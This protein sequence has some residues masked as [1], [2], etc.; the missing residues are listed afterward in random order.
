MKEK[1]N[2]SLNEKKIYDMWEKNGLFTPNMD[3]DKKPF[4]IVIPPPNI[5]G[6]LHIGHALQQ[7]I[8]DII[9]R[10]ERMKGKNTLW[11]VG[12]DHAGIATQIL[13]EQQLKLLEKKDKYEYS[14]DEFIKKTW[15][16]KKKLTQS[17]NN[18]MRRLGNSV[19]WL[20]ERF[21]LDS[22]MSIAVKEAFIRLY[23]KNLIYQRK[24]I[25]HWDIKLQTVISDLEVE[26]RSVLGNLYRI[27]YPLVLDK[28][29]DSNCNHIVV[30]TTRPETLLGDTALAV[31]PEDKRYIKYVGLSV[32]VPIVNRIVPI[33][34]DKRINQKK[35]TGCVKIT[36]GHDFNDYEIALDHKLPMINIFTL[37]GKIRHVL[38]V[39]DV[40]GKES[41]IYTNVVPKNLQYIH[42]DVA[43]QSI[44]DILNTSSLL[45]KIISTTL[46][47]PYG[48]RSGEVIEP[49]LTNQWYLKMAPLAKTAIKAVQDGRIE[50][51]PKKYTKIY[52]NWMNN[53]EDWCISR[54]LWWGHQIPIWFDKHRNIFVGYNEEEVRKK[55]KLSLDT[56]LVQ[57]TDVLDTWFSSSLWTFASLGWPRKTN[58]LKLFHPTNLLVTGFDIIFFWV[59]RMIML[60]M[61]FIHDD[62]GTPQIPF[63]KILVTGLIKD[64]DGKKM[65]K[66]KGNVLDPLDMIDG[67]SLDQLVYKRTNCMMKPKLSKLI[68]ERTKIAFPNGISSTGTDVLRLTLASLSTFNKDINWDHSRLL[69]YRNFCNKVWNASRFIYMN[70]NNTLSSYVFKPHKVLSV[71]NKWILIELNNVIRSYRMSLDIYRFDVAVN[72]LYNFFWNIFCNWYLEFS[73]V[74][75][76]S[77]IIKYQQETRLTLLYVLNTF[78]RLSHPIIPYI[79]ESIWQRVIVLFSNKNNSIMIQPFPEY[80]KMDC[81]VKAILSDIGW[82]QEMTHELRNI[83]KTYSSLINHNLITIYFKSLTVEF[84]CYLKRYSEFLIQLSKVNRLIILND[85]DSFPIGLP[86]Y[87]LGTK[88]VL[89]GNNLSDRDIKDY[90]LNDINKT[91]LLLQH[92]IKFCKNKLLN[93]NFLNHA[94]EKIIQSEREKLFLLEKQVFEYTNRRIHYIK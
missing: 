39:F 61:Y 49:I 54:Q 68:T 90:L 65:S 3:K 53:I 34:A 47:L 22:G 15:I 21:T 32:M 10:Y 35:G 77:T 70:I 83:K 52:F 31:H 16:W 41:A 79:T 19:D 73:K 5:T 9:I 71:L 91:I 30:E 44:V 62:H 13:V 36:P 60:T 20:N 55:Y 43:R 72:V 26:H 14:R 6:N 63:K 78:L 46:I 89:S 1:Y 17:I 88:C 38:Q 25:S 51:I 12:T 67:I 66:S 8:M 11:Q 86:I 59:A 94:P 64:E 24:K 33:I 92:K 40:D 27:C 42:R 29:I 69:N 48:D 80:K 82:I 18:Q 84:K 37:D 57:E 4:C 75:L 50:F 23:E 81:D 2:P 28:H 58:F 74:I 93:K 76:S 85:C 56:L 7:T 87:L 45:K